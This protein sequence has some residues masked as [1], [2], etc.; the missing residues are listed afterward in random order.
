VRNSEHLP[1]IC[2]TSKQSRV[3]FFRLALLVIL[4]TPL[5]AV[6]SQATYYGCQVEGIWRCYSYPGECGY[7]GEMQQYPS[8]DACMQRSTKTIEREA[9]KKEVQKQKK[10]RKQPV[11]TSNKIKRPV[12]ANQPIKPVQN[13]PK[14]VKSHKLQESVPPEIS[15]P[16]VSSQPSPPDAANDLSSHSAD[17]ELQEAKSAAL[18]VMRDATAVLP[19][20]NSEG[21]RSALDATIVAVAEA[22]KGNTSAII[23]ARTEILR[24][25]VRQ[26]QTGQPAN[27]DQQPEQKP[28]GVPQDTQSAIPNSF[29]KRVALVIGNSSYKQGGD[30]L[31][32]RND[33]SQI[34][35]TLGGLGFDV[36]EGTDLDRDAMN[37][38][39]REFVSKQMKAEVALFFYSGQGIQ[40]SG[41]NYLIP[42]DAELAAPTSV[43]TEAVDA[44]SILKYMFGENKVAIVFLDAS[45]DNPFSRRII[46]VL[47]PGRSTVVGRG[48]AVPAAM[49]AGMLISFST[50]PGEVTPDRG[51]ERVSPFTAALLKHLPEKGVE[52]QRVMTEVNADVDSATAGQQSPWYKS[53]LGKAFYLNP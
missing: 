15:A 44:N 34:G 33:A 40:F 24:Q 1:F 43:D 19:L 26:A 51:N 37:H 48:L 52:I 8:H 18:V 27:K 5:L 45:R 47:G 42:T 28:V 9:P 29:R 10:E 39:I 50:S 4:F 35:A 36:I 49:G 11:A 7:Q 22:L 6:A 31:N 14:P 23:R 13:K 41:K 12:K 16:P 21:L 38:K 53:G 3:P 2:R 20:L 32:A 17:S 46:Q 30:L 25:L